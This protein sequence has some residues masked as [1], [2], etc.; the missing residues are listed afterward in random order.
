[1]FSPKII[2][3]EEQK[4]S[5]EG[6][7]D[8]SSD[9]KKSDE[10]KEDKEKNK[11]IFKSFVFEGTTQGLINIMS[12]V[13]TNPLLSY[14]QRLP[15]AVRIAYRVIPDPE[16]EQKLLLIR[17]QSDEL[18]LELFEAA[19][20]KETLKTDQKPIRSFEIARNIEALS[21]AFYI[22]KKEKPQ[23]DKKTPNISEK[24]VSEKKDDKKEQE[25]PREYMLIEEWL[26]LSEQEREKYESPEIPAFIQ[27]TITLHD[28]RKKSKTFEYWFAPAYGIAPVKIK[29][30]V[31]DLPS[32]QEKKTQ[33][34]VQDNAKRMAQ[35]AP[36]T[37]GDKR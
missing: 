16:H 32:A 33:Q 26:K 22:E 27:L 4:K 21:F 8:K 3:A 37:P 18:S 31:S 13:T 15:R 28:E 34:I 12:F 19:T 7:K 9:Q 2:E 36:P 29:G 17:Q 23:T 10:V 14:Q 11:K 1:M 35:Y 25:K 6:N 24:E 30:I 5:A 20:K